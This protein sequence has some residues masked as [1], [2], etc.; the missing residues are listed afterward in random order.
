MD[1]I[2]NFALAPPDM[3]PNGNGS[4]LT[5]FGKM[6]AATAVVSIAVYLTYVLASQL[7]PLLETTK[8][9]SASVGTIQSQH[10]DMKMRFDEQ[11]ENER[12]RGEMMIKLLRANC[13]NSAETKEEKSLC[14]P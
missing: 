7:P 6:S 13:L 10:V 5:G 4:L 2:R 3:T 1:S 9:V 8:E 11:S 12:V 14:N